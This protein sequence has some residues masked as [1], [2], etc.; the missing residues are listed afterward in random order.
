L[1]K[2]AE[3]TNESSVKKNDKK[4]FDLWVIS[5]NRI[6]FHYWQCVLLHVGTKKPNHSLLQKS[7]I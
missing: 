7:F 4:G 2:L 1:T 5:L 6:C 3:G